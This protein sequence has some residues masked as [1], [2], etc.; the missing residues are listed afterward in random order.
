MYL[1]H[2]LDQ[3]PGSRSNLQRIQRL[4]YAL[5]IGSHIMESKDTDRRQLESSLEFRLCWRLFRFCCGKCR[6]V[7]LNT[8]VSRPLA[9]DDAIFQSEVLDRRHHWCSLIH[10]MYGSR[11]SSGMSSSRCRKRKKKCIYRILTC[12]D[13]ENSLNRWS[14][15][16]VNVFFRAP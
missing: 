8:Q 11:Q 16:L 3:P 14:N 4:C 5:D 2:S 7:N 6:L 1:G 10:R 15:T 13:M 12:S 9:V